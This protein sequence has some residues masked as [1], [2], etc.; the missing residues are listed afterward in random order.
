MSSR[1]WNNVTK[2]IVTASLTLLTIV[3]LVTFRQ[4][5]APT[6]VAFLLAF[7]LGYPVDWIQRSTG[8]PRGAA[9]VV[10]FVMLIAAIATGPL[11][12]APRSD[13]LLAALTD[14]L[15]QLLESLP[16]GP[17][18]LLG[19]YE[20]SLDDLLIQAGEAVSG[21]LVSIGNPLNIARGLT[22]GLLSFVYVL[23]LTFWVLKDLY[24]LQRLMLEQIPLDYQEDA[25]LLAQEIGLIWHAFLRGQLILGITVG[26]MTW[27]ALSIVGMPNAG[28]LALLAGVMEFLPSLGPAI[29]GTIGS[30]VALFQ[31]STWLP[32]SN[33]GFTLIVAGIYFVIGQIESIY[34]IP[35]LVGRRIQLHPAVTFVGLITGTMVFGFLGLLLA[36]PT[37]ASVRSILSY[38]YRKLLDLE[39]F[40]PIISPQSGVRIPGLIAGRKIEAILFDLDGTLAKP[41]RYAQDWVETHLAWLDGILAPATRRDIARRMMMIAEGMVSSTVSISRYVRLELQLLRFQPF[42]DLARGFPPARS[43]ETIPRVPDMIETLAVRYRLVLISTRNRD[44][45]RTFL[46]RAD[47]DPAHFA[48]IVDRERV[49]NLL[50]A[51]EPLELVISTLELERNQVL[52]VSDTDLNLRTARSAQMATAGVLCGLGREND[53]RDV[54]LVLETTPDLLDW[55]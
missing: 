28:G 46:R 17:I 3:V 18:P 6:V 9:I 12:L 7:V 41:D 22:T 21:I 42:L 38:L 55:L 1:R 32:V 14:T 43:L 4:M 34:L 5:I 40:D 15:D 8:W 19:A 53:L 2:I 31:G 11:I 48:L 36:A 52:V 16:S 30:A 37:I 39:P 35:R 51:N 27:I 47:I 54:D 44:E 10:V 25:R 49:R 13:D 23:V 26:T 33:L 29:S 45:I 50:P 24:K 20:L